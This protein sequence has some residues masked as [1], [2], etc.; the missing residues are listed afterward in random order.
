MEKDVVYYH[1]WVIKLKYWNKPASFLIVSFYWCDNIPHFSPFSCDSPITPNA[2]LH[3][4]DMTAT[5]SINDSTLHSHCPAHS[6]MH[7]H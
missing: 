5:T 7:V 2:L 4:S 3:I 1:V 6:D